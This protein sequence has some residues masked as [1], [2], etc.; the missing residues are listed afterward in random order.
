MICNH[1]FEIGD[2]KHRLT[3]S[4]GVTTLKKEDSIETVTNRVT[5]AL[6]EAK[7]IKG[8]NNTKSIS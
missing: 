7:S 3:V 6:N 2:N 8:K 4:C 1:I 5:N